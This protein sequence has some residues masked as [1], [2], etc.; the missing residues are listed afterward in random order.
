MLT[1]LSILSPDQG[2]LRASPRSDDEYF[3]RFASARPAS[4]TTSRHTA[5]QRT[6]KT[7]EWLSRIFHHVVRSGPGH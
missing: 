4:A 3:A 2:K 6:R 5:S 1:T 7:A